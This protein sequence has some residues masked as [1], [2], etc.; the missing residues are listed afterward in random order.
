M[1]RLMFA[2]LTVFLWLC[3]CETSGSGD[4][5]AETGTN[6]A[7]M[8]YH[9]RVR[10]W[11]VF[12][13]M[14][15]GSGQTAGRISGLSLEIIRKTVRMAGSGGL[16]S[17]TV[18]VGFDGNLYRLFMTLAVYATQD[19]KN[20]LIRYGLIQNE[21]R[22][23]VE[24]SSDEA[25]RKERTGMFRNP[26][27]DAWIGGNCAD[28]S[29][30][31]Q[32]YPFAVSYLLREILYVSVQEFLSRP[33]RYFNLREI[34]TPFLQLV[35]LPESAEFAAY[36]K[37]KYGP[38]KTLA[39]SRTEFSAAAWK[40]I[41]GEDIHETEADFSSIAE[42]RRYRGALSDPLRVREFERLLK[43]FHRTTKPALF[44]KS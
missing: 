37:G 25:A 4:F 41:F 23:W 43:L 16:P 9:G 18:Q 6:G 10:S 26:E 11:P 28:R 40:G 21:W 33:A 1:M 22:E 17:E 5:R 14:N 19:M 7:V 32:V 13:V 29:D 31:E 39:A 27:L 2:F 35:S 12:E 42:N 8:I 24:T 36:L 38:G 30:R 20:D 34:E 3:S 15:T 44:R